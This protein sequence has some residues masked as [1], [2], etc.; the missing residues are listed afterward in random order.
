MLISR[1]AFHRGPYITCAFCCSDSSHLQLIIKFATNKSIALYKTCY[2]VDVGQ[3]TGLR[4][5]GF[6]AVHSVHFSKTPSLQA[7]LDFLYES[8]PLIFVRQGADR[9]SIGGFT[10]AI[11]L[12]SDFPL[13]NITNYQRHRSIRQIITRIQMV[14]GSLWHEPHTVHHKPWFHWGRTRWQ[15]ISNFSWINDAGG[16]VGMGNLGESKSFRLHMSFNQ[17]IY[18]RFGSDRLWSATSSSAYCSPSAC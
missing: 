11:S 6:I 12:R 14:Y 2:A 9:L 13:D 8:P 17:E 10:G 5:A 1:R 15:Y 7:R 16:I 3:V 18:T 4:E